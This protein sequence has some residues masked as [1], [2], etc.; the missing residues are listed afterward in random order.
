M[1]Y[2][3]LGVT[4]IRVSV[5]SF[6]AGPVAA[7]MTG[8]PDGGCQHEAVRRAVR[9]GV[10]WFDTAAT[11]GDG[12]SESNLGEALHRLAP[13]ATPHVATKARLMPEDLSD[14]GGSIR[15]SVEGSLVRLRRE[16]VTL[17]Q[18]HNS[19]TPG[20]GDMYTSVTPADV[21]GPGGVLEAFERLQAE[22]LVGHI[23]LTGL[24]ERQ[25]LREVIGSG[26]FATVQTPF[27]MLS[28]INQ[29]GSAAILEQC[30]SLGMGVFA[31]RVFAGGA[32]AG[33]PPSAH[34]LQTRFFPLDLYQRDAALAASMAESLSPDVPLREAA[35]RFVLGRREVSSALVGFS[36]ADQIE[37][38]AQFAARGGLPALCP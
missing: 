6:G 33:R 12:R 7:L 3:P 18:L 4:G 36:S 9:L 11:Y 14:I 5:V 20:Q 35:V 21:L 38:V 37:E 22:K 25:A 26:A 23:G 19:I 16:Q 13:E 1:E 27:N 17:L 29:D 31:I 28:K 32:L 34:T 10:N 8:C 2:R 30:E 24:G 15:R